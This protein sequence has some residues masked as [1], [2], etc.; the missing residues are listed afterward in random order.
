MKGR[1]H[2]RVTANDNGRP[3]SIHLRFALYHYQ[4]MPDAILGENWI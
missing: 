3:K 1:G 4:S 2:K